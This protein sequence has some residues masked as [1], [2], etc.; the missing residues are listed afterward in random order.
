[1]I[2]QIHGSSHNI[3]FVLFCLK[4]QKWKKKEKIL[5]NDWITNKITSITLMYFQVTLYLKDL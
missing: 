3:F 1:M 2:L 5:A 4:K